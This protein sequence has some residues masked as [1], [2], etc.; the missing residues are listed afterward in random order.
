MIFLF[1]YFWLFSNLNRLVGGD[2]RSHIQLRNR[3]KPFKGHT[4]RAG[5]CAIETVW[6]RRNTAK[7]NQ[8]VYNITT[9]QK[10]GTVYGTAGHKWSPTC[11]ESI[12]ST[13]VP[14]ACTKTAVWHQDRAKSCRTKSHEQPPREKIKAKSQ[15]YFYSKKKEKKYWFIQEKNE[16]KRTTSG[17]KSKSAGRNELRVRTVTF[18]FLFNDSPLQKSPVTATVIK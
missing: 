14:R 7:L 16:R 1:Y 8:S 9:C 17:T 2:P 18:L 5:D 4:Q 11:I 12:M 13:P 15:K 10:A 6:P 3:N